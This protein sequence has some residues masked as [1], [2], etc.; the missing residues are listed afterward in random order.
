MCKA[1]ELEQLR[2]EKAGAVGGSRKVPEQMPGAKT[3]RI[4]LEHA[5]A[6]RLIIVHWVLSC[7]TQTLLQKRAA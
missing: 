4:E 5:S 2:L 7:P 3:R 1:W 6:S